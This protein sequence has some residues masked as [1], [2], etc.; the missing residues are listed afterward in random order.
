MRGLEINPSIDAPWVN[1]IE[2]SGQNVILSQLALKS[3][4]TLVRLI[5]DHC[6][7]PVGDRWL[8][9]SRNAIRSCV[10]AYI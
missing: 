4:L 1:C 7:G 10:C 3:I 8:D 6:A 9:E 2:G 5:P